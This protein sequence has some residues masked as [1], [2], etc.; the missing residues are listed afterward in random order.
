M[1]LFCIVMVAQLFEQGVGLRKG[2]DLLCG[3]EWR[4]AFLPEVVRALDLSF[5][6]GSRRVAQ[7]D[8]A[9]AQGAAELGQSLWLTGE[10]EA[11][12]I[13][14]EGQRQPV[15]AKGGREEIEMSR[16]VFAL[17]EGKEV[18]PRHIV[19]PQS[20]PPEVKIAKE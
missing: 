4:E 13:D 20:A 19:E 6:L 7:G 11:M 5:G 17:V 10:E 18:V 16:E 15:L 3:E 14:V 8:F 2:R 12:V 1:D 9:K